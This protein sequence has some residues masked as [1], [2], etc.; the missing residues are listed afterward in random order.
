[1]YKSAKLHYRVHL[2]RSERGH[3]VRRA[4]RDGHQS[5]QLRIRLVEIVHQR[6]GERRSSQIRRPLKDRQPQ[7]GGRF[8]RS[9]PKKP[10]R[11]LPPT[12]VDG[13][14]LRPPHDLDLVGAGSRLQ[15]PVETV[16]EGRRGLE[17][18]L[19][20]RGQLFV[21]IVRFGPRNRAFARFAQ[22]SPGF[23]ANHRRKTLQ[24]HG[25]RSGLVRIQAR[26]VTGRRLRQRRGELDLRGHARDYPSGED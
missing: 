18:G 6:D 26:P 25:I 10:Q 14:R 9:P 1:M 11:H 8:R 16:V 15:T 22:L 5:A 20:I 23:Q 21:R 2:R 24:G 7:L 3:E 13:I 17:F 19:R 12:P 4:R